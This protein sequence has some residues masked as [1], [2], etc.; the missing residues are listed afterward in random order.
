MWEQRVGKVFLI[1]MQPCCSNMSS[2]L[3]PFHE[4][5]IAGHRGGGGG[6]EGKLNKEAAHG[7]LVE[8]LNW[9]ATWIIYLIF[10]TQFK[11][12]IKNVW[13][14]KGKLLFH[15]LQEFDPTTQ[16]TE[17]NVLVPRQD[18]REIMCIYFDFSCRHNFEYLLVI[19]HLNITNL[20]LDFW[21]RTL[22]SLWVL[23]IFRSRNARS[24]F[25]VHQ[26]MRS[27][28]WQ[29]RELD[30]TLSFQKSLLKLD[31]SSVLLDRNAFPRLFFEFRCELKS[32]SLKYF[33]VA[34]RHELRFDEM[35]LMTWY[36]HVKSRWCGG[37]AQERLSKA[38]K[39]ETT[40]NEHQFYFF[41]IWKYLVS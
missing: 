27:R 29:P 38:F 17:G 41:A 25:H 36:L 8:V 39:T 22:F 20:L 13:E 9:L 16:V 34:G 35:L 10:S 3:A 18:H 24:P 31:L 2:F 28:C 26:A 15:F 5:L 19:S 37:G 23:P 1:H 11:L 6:G 40:L 12:Y 21:F 30:H 33:L 32:F 14:S 7:Y 4:Y